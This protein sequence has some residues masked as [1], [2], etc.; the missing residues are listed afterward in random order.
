[1]NPVFQEIIG[2]KMTPNTFDEAKFGEVLTEIFAKVAEIRSMKLLLPVV[3]MGEPSNAASKLLAAALSSMGSRR[4]ND[5]QIRTLVLGPVP[6]TVINKIHDNAMDCKN[7]LA[8]FKP[9]HHLCLDLKN[10]EF[11]AAGMAKY[12][13]GL[14]R[15]IS[16]AQ[17]LESLSLTGD[18]G[19]RSITKRTIPTESRVARDR[20]PAMAIPYFPLAKE[21]RFQKLMAVELTRVN[22]SPRH[23]LQMLHDCSKS[24]SELYL[25]EVYLKFD[26]HNAVRVPH[27]WIGTGL[28][29]GKH[30]ND[31]WV[32][33]E[34]K[35]MIEKGTLNLKVLRASG[36]GY[37]V[38][39]QAGQAPTN[40]I[41]D[42]NDPTGQGRCFDQRFVEAVLGSGLAGPAGLPESAAW[43]VKAYQRHHNTTSAHK[44]SLD[45][46]FQLKGD[47]TYRL[48]Q[49]LMHIVD[50]GMKTLTDDINMISANPDVVP[51]QPPATDGS[52]ATAATAATAS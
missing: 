3:F 42:L 48:A 35:R 33:V 14:W 11:T 18:H 45:G 32:A 39:N 9:L 6:D 43:S 23:L 49:Q 26:C 22:I 46:N 41:F 44:S 37:D 24:L 13:A 10:H 34:I 27:Y 2:Y 5:A 25:N 1:M 8:V 21:C 30:D 52:A 29:N 17:E 15:F 12:A 28:E 38:I 4:A 20:W 31:I 47:K 40:D 7:A 16:E 19:R 50:R 51:A 36:L